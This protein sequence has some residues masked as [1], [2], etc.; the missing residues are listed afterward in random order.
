MKISNTPLSLLVYVGALFQLSVWPDDAQAAILEYKVKKG[1]LINEAVFQGE[2]AAVESVRISAPVFNWNVAESLN[3][4]WLAD[5]GKVVKKGDF[6]LEFEDA[7]LRNKLINAKDETNLK[8]AEF[9]R[10]KGDLDLEKISLVSQIEVKKMELEKGKLN[11]VE[12]DIISEVEREK[13]KLDVKSRQIEYELLLE[14]MKKFREKYQSQMESEKIE[15]EIKKR[16]LETVQ[17]LFDKL[18]VLAPADGMLFRPFT[19]LNW[20]KGKV[21]LGSTI[22]SGDFIMEIPKLDKYKVTCY[23]PPVDAEHF[24]EGDKAEI[25]FVAFPTIAMKGSLESMG[26]GAMTRNERLGTS[27]KEGNILERKV[28]FSMEGVDPKLRP[29]LTTMVKVKSVI[30]QNVLRI[31]HIAIFKKENPFCEESVKVNER[32]CIEDSFSA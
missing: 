28:E 25:R 20:V 4:K 9:Q 26:A 19:S 24:K 14:N 15:L 1:N 7:A 23:L 18:K 6:I 12:G 22:A 3:V 32:G 8:I 16:E 13:A 27:H 31:P 2:L 5:E 11:V 17:D 30:A 29:G 10:E 21:A